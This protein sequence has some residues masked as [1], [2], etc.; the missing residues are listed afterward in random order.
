VK[1][2]FAGSHTYLYGSVLVLLG[3]ASWSI[4]SVLIRLTEGG[5]WTITFWRS[6]FQITVLFCWLAWSM[7]RQLASLAR[8][9]H[10]SEI[11]SGLL[12]GGML[13][14]WVPAL[15]NTTV[16]GALVLQ[17]T[18]PIFSALLGAIFLGEQIGRRTVAVI[19]AAIAGVAI[20][21]GS[22]IIGGGVIGDL[23]ALTTAVFFGANVVLLR[24]GAGTGCDFTRSILVSGLVAV[25]PGIVTASVTPIGAHDLVLCFFM[26]CTQTVGFILFNSGAKMIPAAD[27]GLVIPM[28]AVLGSILTAIV[29][30]E[31]PSSM[32][33]VG[34]VLVLTAIVVN[35]V[36]SV[37][38]SRA[39]R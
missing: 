10:W 32:A 15:R 19:A 23:L 36:G 35:I 17:G 28:E 9:I 6:F 21:F 14:L 25:A 26:G 16:A 22:D 7:R 38:E 13:V 11:L 3:S 4:T 29:I 5:T 1:A 34:A 24:S 20:M 27:T 8:P 18:A 33:I 37:A 30:G 12:V 2:R 31:I 39:T